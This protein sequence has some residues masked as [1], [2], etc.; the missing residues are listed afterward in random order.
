MHIMKM[1]YVTA[2]T[3]KCFKGHLGAAMRI[4][5]FVLVPLPHFLFLIGVTV[6]SGTVGM[7]YYIGKCTKIIYNHEYTKTM[8]QI[9]S[10]AKLEPKS[11]LGKY[12]KK[13]QTF[14]KEDEK[15]HPTIYILKGCI[16]AVP[17]VVLGV[18]PFIPFTIAMVGITLLRLP[19]NL[20]KT[21]KIAL[22]TVVLKWDLKFI[23]LFTCPLAHI[24]F[25]LLVFIASLLESLRYFTYRT[26][27]NI[28]KGHVPFEKW[29]WFQDGISDYYKQHQLFVGEFCHDYDHPSGIPLGW[30][31]QRYGIPVAKVLRWQ[32]DIIV[33]CFLVIYSTPIVILGS[34]ILAVGWILPVIG[35]YLY[36]KTT[37][38]CSGSCLE[39]MSTWPFY[40]VIML[41]IP[42]LV[43]VLF[44]LG[45]V[46]TVITECFFEIPKLYFTCGFVTGLYGPF[47]TIARLDI[48][49]DSHTFEKGWR[50]L[51]CLLDDD[52]NTNAILRERRSNS[53]RDTPHNDET[54]DQYWDRFISQCIKTTSELIEEKW[55]TAEDVESMDPAVITSIPAI[56]VLDI[57]VDSAIEKG[58]EEEDIKWSIDG[59]VCKKK[60]R[61]T[62]DAILNFLWP[63]ICDMKQTLLSNSELLIAERKSDS[64]ARTIIRAMLCDNGN[65]STKELTEFLNLN[66]TARNSPKN[67][68]LRSK[69]T[70]FVLEMTRLGPYLN[71]MSDIYSREKD[72]I[73]TDAEEGRCSV[74]SR[75]SSSGM[76]S[77]SKAEECETQESVSAGESVNQEND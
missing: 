44:V 58:L 20:Y 56:A 33:C 4:S 12:Y 70:N 13:C 47:G 14:M 16:A 64:D 39:I 7:L 54:P 27:R 73:I 17:G 35:F 36:R 21:M 22:G 5:V 6:F 60:D 28:Y 52:E 55:I 19:I 49:G 31:G 11:H 32:R 41:L 63:L 75:I 1:L 50:F 18:I 42:P 48:L 72:E 53:D 65:D 9:E 3:D 68:L 26:S 23:A 40:V 37:N 66:E 10:N 71:R 46:F 62:N 29:G 51:P 8:K 57:L 24:I 15:S 38:Y 43:A 76:S 67:K 69:V 74:V 77:E 2:T 59:T 45:I 34:S 61:P 30:N 25:P